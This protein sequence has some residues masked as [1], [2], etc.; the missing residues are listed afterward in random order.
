MQV[1][2]KG[3]RVLRQISGSATKSAAE[4]MDWKYATKSA[5][6]PV[7]SG[8]M[9]RAKPLRQNLLGRQN[10]WRDCKDCGLNL[11]VIGHICGVYA[12]NWRD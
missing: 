11:G 6:E 4:S 9:E 10:K 7:E 2:S 12:S 8:R 5:A 1:A 3:V